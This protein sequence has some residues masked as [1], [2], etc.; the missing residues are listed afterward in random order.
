MKRYSMA[1]TWV[2]AVVGA[3]APLMGYVG[4]SGYVDSASLVMAAVLF[5]WQ[6]PHFNSLSWNIRGDYTRAGYRVMCAV[7][8]RLCRL[9]SLRYS[10]A[11][12]LLCSLGAPMTGLTAWSFALESLPFNAL[13]LHLSYKFYRNADAKTSR[14]LFHYTLLHLPLIM[15]L[16]AVSKFGHSPD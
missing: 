14:S 2:G 8:Q 6:F 3:I 10:L 5:C 13:L 15:M 11:L 16:M 4:A 12:L 1:C 7:N 9:T